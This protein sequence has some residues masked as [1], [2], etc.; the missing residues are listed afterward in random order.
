MLINQPLEHGH[1]VTKL[2]R[3]NA[4]DL[5]FIIPY[6]NLDDFFQGRIFGE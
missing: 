2:R 3:R 6:A 4:C 1:E 5:A